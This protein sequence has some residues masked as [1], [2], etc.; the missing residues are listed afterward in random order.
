VTWPLGDVGSVR[1]VAAKDKIKPRWPFVTVPVVLAF[2]IVSSW[3]TRLEGT[4]LPAT[5]QADSLVVA[6][7]KH[8]LTVYAQGRAVKTYRVALARGGMDDKVQQGDKR[9][10]V[11]RLDI[12]RRS[13]SGRRNVRI[14]RLEHVVASG[15]IT[16]LDL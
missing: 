15:G 10:P 5:L 6:K 12:L 16:A 1:T 3:S 9:V 13:A 2:A 4:P 14:A 8:E 11:A 7:A